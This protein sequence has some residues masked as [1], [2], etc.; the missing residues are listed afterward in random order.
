MVRGEFMSSAQCVDVAAIEGN[1]SRGYAIAPDVYVC[2]TADGS[3]ILDLKRDKYLGMSR[4]QTESLAM[5]V[6]AWPAPIWDRLPE[7][8][9]RTRMLDP[10][11]DAVCK[12]LVDE[13]LLIHSVVDDGLVATRDRL[14]DGRRCP[15]MRG[16]W[17]SVGDEMEVG[18]VVGIRDV[19]NFAAAFVWARCSLA[20]RPIIATV[21]AV[22][23][24][25]AAAN[26]HLGWN[27][28]R[29]AALIDAFRSLRPYV[30]A[31]E[32]RC[33]LHALT[34]VRFLSHYG[35]YPEWVIG[36]ATQPW[37]AHSWV[38]WERF[39]LDTNPEKVCGYTPILVV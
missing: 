15:D 16:E 25:K 31:P 7:S 3:V 14:G 37:G 22:K 5:A 38:Q 1:C 17:T 23:K 29:V 19:M 11:A 2:V 28:Q 36:V 27:P 20:W 30:F 33:L 12:G 35:F 32:G 21:R 10:G 34:L 4:E 24:C 18:S 9:C 26:P 39:L 13:G 8:L 6:P